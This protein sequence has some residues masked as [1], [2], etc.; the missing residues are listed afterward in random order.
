MPGS[1]LFNLGLYQKN[2]LSTSKVTGPAINMGCTRGR[3]STTRMLN[4]CTQHSPAPSLCIDQFVT[5]NNNK[6]NNNN[7]DTGIN[8]SLG[9]RLLRRFLHRVGNVFTLTRNLS[10]PRIY[11][12]IIQSGETLHI[13]GGRT[14]NM[15]F[16]NNGTINVTGG[17]T[18]IIGGVNIKTFN[19]NLKSSTTN[20]INAGTISLVTGTSHEVKSGNTLN[21]YGTISCEN[22]AVYTINGIL[23]NYNLIQCAGASTISI[24]K[25]LFNYYNTGIILL[26]GN[27]SIN[28]NDGGFLYMASPVLYP[29]PLGYSNASF[30]NN[31]I[32]YFYSS[33][34]PAAGPI[35]TDKVPP[36]IVIYNNGN[37]YI[38]MDKP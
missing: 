25:V 36:S 6:Y 30:T 14:C 35:Y 37:L 5:F 12:V 24:N 28:L 26:L 7:N 23:N 27:S 3:G 19:K 38:C 18:L 13:S 31:P 20:S 15:R 10:L 21:N 11:N 22:A 1:H 33:T 9:S 2:F 17:S 4:W 8:I 29:S 16:T 34:Q 32:T